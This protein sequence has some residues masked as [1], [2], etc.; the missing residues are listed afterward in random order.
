[1]ARRVAGP[2]VKKRGMMKIGSEVRKHHARCGQVSL[3]Q[4]VGSEALRLAHLHRVP[5]DITAKTTTRL[6]RVSAIH[7]L[8]CCAPGEPAD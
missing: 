5:T 2:L 3:E 1:M 8:D 7:E 6:M 4:A